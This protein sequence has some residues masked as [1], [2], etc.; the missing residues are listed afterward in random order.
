MAIIERLEGDLLRRVE[1]RKRVW[2]RRFQSGLKN[3]GFVYQFQFHERR[4]LE[5]YESNLKW[6]N[7]FEDRLK[8]EMFR[9]ELVAVFGQAYIPGIP[10]E[11]V[12][13][14][15]WPLLQKP[16]RE[17]SASDQSGREV[18][19]LTYSSLRQMNKRW[20]HLVSFSYEWAVYRMVRR[21]FNE[22]W[23]W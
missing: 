5:K 7:F 19:L 8:S 10:D 23:V 13:K 18:V 12:E 16:F 22:G 9:K 17:I 21:D 2:A 20:K 14:H 11:I 4:Y 6:L 15:I 1:E 3:L